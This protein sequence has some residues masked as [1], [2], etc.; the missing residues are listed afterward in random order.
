[1]K[2]QRFLS[3]FLAAAVLVGLLC[4][5]ALAAPEDNSFEA[6]TVSAKAALLLQS[7]IIFSFSADRIYDG[8]IPSCGSQDYAFSF[9]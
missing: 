5:A 3:T 2:K 7:E 1:M 9:L 6:I 8:N 4:P